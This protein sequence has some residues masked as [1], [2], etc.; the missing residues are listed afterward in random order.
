M[1]SQKD[2]TTAETKSNTPA[3]PPSPHLTAG[4]ASA[5]KP[6]TTGSPSAKAGAT[7]GVQDTDSASS[8]SSS[9]DAGEEFSAGIPK[10]E[11]GGREREPTEDDI[12]AAK[13]VGNDSVQFQEALAEMAVMEWG[14]RPELKEQKMDSIKAMPSVSV[15]SGVIGG[16]RAA[17]VGFFEFVQYL[18]VILALITEL[19]PQVQKII[20]TIRNMI[21]QNVAPREAMMDLSRFYRG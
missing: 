15:V 21:G 2:T 20:D 18:P 7:S 3:S 10:G 12:S 6:G 9:K 11:T 17:G 13:K 16:L 4:G 14:K 5:G 1:S 8:P 19:G